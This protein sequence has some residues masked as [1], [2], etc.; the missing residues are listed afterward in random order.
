[1]IVKLLMAALVASATLAP[2]ASNSVAGP[3]VVENK[4]DQCMQRCSSKGLPYHR[5]LLVC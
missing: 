3:N 2:L 1:M 4:K 5:C